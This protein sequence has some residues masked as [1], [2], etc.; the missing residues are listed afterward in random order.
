MLNDAHAACTGFVPGLGKHNC[1]VVPGQ[2]E[3]HEGCANAQDPATELLGSR[4][5]TQAP[6]GAAVDKLGHAFR[7]SLPSSHSE[8]RA[9]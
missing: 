9:Q 7:N 5:N 4:C 1:S 3:L 2:S 8:N 6:L